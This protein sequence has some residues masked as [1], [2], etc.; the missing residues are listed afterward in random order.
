MLPELPL[1][2]DL[3]LPYS[4]RIPCAQTWLRLLPSSYLSLN[5]TVWISVHWTVSHACISKHH[6]NKA[7][8]ISSYLMHCTQDVTQPPCFLQEEL[9]SSILLQDVW[10]GILERTTV[11]F[12]HGRDPANT[13]RTCQVIPA[14]FCILDTILSKRFMNSAPTQHIVDI[15]R[16]LSYYHKPEKLVT[17]W[18][19]SFSINCLFSWFWHFTSLQIRE[20]TSISKH[21]ICAALKGQWH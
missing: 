14:R 15:M 10:W 6:F 19:W 13:H 5:I 18:P 9:R 2:P 8:A 20:D 16:H 1:T 4:I 21:Q 7:A 12:I 17:W 3:H 11:Q